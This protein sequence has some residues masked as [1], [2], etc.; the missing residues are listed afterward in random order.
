MIKKMVMPGESIAEEGESG[1]TDDTDSVESYP[2]FV[3]IG[4]IDE[5]PGPSVPSPLHTRS[6]GNAKKTKVTA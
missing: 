6:Y 2:G 3:S 1:D 5:S 4:D